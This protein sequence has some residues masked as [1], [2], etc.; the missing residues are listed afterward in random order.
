MLIYF[1]KK[2]K[3]GYI[4]MLN[5]K[6][7]HKYSFKYPVFLFEIKIKNIL[8]KKKINIK[9]ISKYQ[10]NIR[11]ITLIIDKKIPIDNLIKL[12]KSI[13]EKI[14]KKINIIKI[15][16]NNLKKI[17]KKNITLR[18]NIQDNNKT[19]KTKEINNIIY[20][21]KKKLKKKFNAIIN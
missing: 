11:D 4:G 13:N 19:L 17:K 12:C 10:N 3:I 15:Y 5:K 1:L 21:C 16:N 6:I 14:I 2:K 8:F 9:K 20:I 7:Q 18:L